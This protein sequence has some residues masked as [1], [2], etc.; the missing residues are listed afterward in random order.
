MDRWPLTASL[1]AI[2]LTGA[3]VLL[4][5]WNGTARDMARLKET[6]PT[7]RLALGDD[8]NT[9]REQS[10]YRFPPRTLG[11]IDVIAAGEPVIFEYARP[12]CDFR[13]P[14]ARSFAAAVDDGHAVSVT[15]SPQLSYTSLGGAL[16]LIAQI[17]AALGDRRWQLSKR[18]LNAD[19]IRSRFGD[20][21]VN[22]DVTVRVEDWRCGDDEV[23]V[24]LARH[25]RAGESLPQL[26]GKEHDFCLVS[27]KIE[28]DR[29]R[30]QYPG[31]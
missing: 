21:T 9:I 5:I 20:L 3:A 11:R 30:R 31:S 18:Y 4:M 10:T 8:F 27:L 6:L 12:G 7:I 1:L 28:N 22:S 26:A 13:L 24:E 25:W 29:V 16:D 14:P 23:Y 15:V 19:Q 17:G 2:G